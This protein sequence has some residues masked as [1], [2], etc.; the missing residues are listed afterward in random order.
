MMADI[1]EHGE[2]SA[3]F[4]YVQRIENQY[5]ELRLFHAI[6]NGAKLGWGRDRDGNRY[7]R[8]GVKLKAEGLRPGVPDY[9]LPAIRL[10]YYGLY[11]ELKVGRNVPSS[12]QIF[13]L[14]LARNAG[15]RATCCWGFDAARSVLD[16]YLGGYQE[17]HNYIFYGTPES[18]IGKLRE[19]ID[20]TAQ[21]LELERF[22]Y[23]I[24]L[25]EGE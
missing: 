3:L 11:I 22:H 19:S 16:R 21:G 7:S 18:L 5:P 17:M 10:P 13:F 12:D 14:L 6:P 20:D 25:I 2:A 1:T 9:F 23:K 24:K 8:E 4:D 15:Y